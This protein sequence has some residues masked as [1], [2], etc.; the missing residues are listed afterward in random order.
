MSISAKVYAP[1]TI[2]VHL[3]LYSITHTSHF[4]IV[5]DLLSEY[6]PINNPTN[7]PLTVIDMPFNVGNDRASAQW[8][9]DVA[10]RVADLSGFKHVIIFIT[11]HSDPERGDL[12][13]GQ[14]ERGE[15][16]A[17]PV[18]NVCN[19]IFYYFLLILSICSIVV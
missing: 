12:W 5:E 7:N 15:I 19:N 16:C 1:P 6:Y 14:D 4:K 2:L 9:S 17:A 18:G 11:T 8:S 13:L 3:R 10:A